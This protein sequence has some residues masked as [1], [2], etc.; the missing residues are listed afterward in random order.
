MSAT[1]CWS[2][3]ERG[4]FAASYLIRALFSV[5]I[6]VSVSVS[7]ADVGATGGGETM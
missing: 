1:T 6:V 3:E 2:V 7:T 4:G 5:G